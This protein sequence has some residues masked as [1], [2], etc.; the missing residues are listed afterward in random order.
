MNQKEENFVMSLIRE[1]LKMQS[2]GNSIVINTQI[3]IINTYN[4]NFFAP[5]AN[6]TD[7]FFSRKEGSYGS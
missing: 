3:H 2:L 5:V 6:V 1:R 7:N 4:L